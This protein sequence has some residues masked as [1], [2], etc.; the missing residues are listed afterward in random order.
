MSCHAAGAQDLQTTRMHVS[1]MCFAETDIV[2]LL[3]SSGNWAGCSASHP[4]IGHHHGAHTD[5]N[6][7]ECTPAAAAQTPRAPS[8]SVG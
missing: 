7:L 3:F 5:E 2:N 4:L 8:R 6:A 1:E